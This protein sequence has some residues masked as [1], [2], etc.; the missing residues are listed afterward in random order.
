[1]RPSLRLIVLGW[2]RYE[3]LRFRYAIYRLRCDRGMLERITVR[4][5][6]LTTQEAEELAQIG[7]PPTSNEIWRRATWPLRPARVGLPHPAAASDG[8]LLRLEEHIGD[9][10]MRGA[11]G[12]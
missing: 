2:L 9:A 6:R 10:S 4:A 5:A 1:M 8:L 7:L 3:F 12:R 11:L